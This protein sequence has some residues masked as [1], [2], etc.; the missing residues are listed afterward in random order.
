M[1]KFKGQV[2]DY[3][4]RSKELNET[5]DCTV[6][7][8]AKVLNTTYDKAHKHLREECKRKNRKRI[9]SRTELPKSL[10][11]TKFVVGEYSKTNRITVKQ[12]CEKHPIGRFY[13]CVRGHAFAIVDGCVYDYCDKPRRQITWA[14]RVYID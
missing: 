11:R 12:F 2:E 7:A 5:N 1:Y 3:I 10:K 14:M 8:L 6:K 9:V 4:N 13:V